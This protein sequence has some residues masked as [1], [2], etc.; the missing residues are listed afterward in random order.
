MIEI[1]LIAKVW[2]WIR[3]VAIGISPM[4]FFE[5]SY[6]SVCDNSYEKHVRVWLWKI[7]EGSIWTCV[8]WWLIWG[9]E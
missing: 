5:S 8:L 4:M 3:I 2:F 9:Q 7:T 1:I 6:Q